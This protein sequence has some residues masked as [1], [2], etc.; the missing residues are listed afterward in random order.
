MR[1]KS[2]LSGSRGASKGA[3]RATKRITTPTKPPSADRVL[4]RAKR[5]SSTSTDVI[6]GLAVADA[7]VEPRVAEVD[8]D[9]DG[10]EDY[11]VEQDEVLHDDNVALDHRDDERAPEAG[12]AERLLDRHRATQHE[13]Q[14]H[15]GDGDDRQ[16]RVGQR[17]PKHDQSFAK[18]L[19]PRRPHEVFADD[20]QEARARHAGDVGPLRQAEDDAGPDDDLQVLPRALPEV[21]DHD[22]RLV[23]EPEQQRE[24]DEHAEP[25]ARDGDE[26]HRQRARDAVRKAVRLERAQDPH[27]K[28][29]Q[30]G[31]DEGQHADLRADRAAV[32]DQRGYGVAPEER[33]AETPGSDVAEPA[34]VLY[35]QR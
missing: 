22:G 30:P 28:T 20:L 13:A 32:R 15:A 12:H 21:D 33:L 24:D 35:G 16:E 7:R 23:A 17:V 6:T 2:A 1:R 19:G 4:R 34:D 27:G 14:Q 26:Q 5:A 25:E 11:G 8:Q 3:A 10:D 31:D 29:D 9:V 18:P